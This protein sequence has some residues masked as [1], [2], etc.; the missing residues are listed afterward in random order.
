[1]DYIYL[2]VALKY[3]YISDMNCE[4]KL[5]CYKSWKLAVFS[6][7]ICLLEGVYNLRLE[8][9]SGKSMGFGYDHPRVKSSFYHFFNCEL[10]QSYLVSPNLNFLHYQMGNVI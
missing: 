2:S 3:S 6:K 4:K 9:Y 1:M 5:Y 8:W 10:D 7:M